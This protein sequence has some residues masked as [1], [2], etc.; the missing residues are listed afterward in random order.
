M[1]HPLTDR[2][3]HGV[4][5]TGG[6]TAWFYELRL[7]EPD[8]RK[9]RKWLMLTGVL[10]ILG[11]AAAII[12]PPLATLTM[13]VFIGWILVYAGVVMAV[14]SW[15]QRKAGRTWDRALLAL[16]AF[17]IGV[18]MVLFPDDGA[19]TLTL[20]LVIWF[21]ASG[22]VQLVAARQLWG[23]PGVGWMVFGGVLSILLAALVA[24]DLPSSAAWAIGLLV[25]VNLV[26][27]GVRALVAA[28]LLKRAFEP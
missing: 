5:P 14:H 12:V 3:F 23:L 21:I 4:A 20:L 28:S 19:L 9:A 13:T 8:L 25:G 7:S 26:F 15:T 22:V 17:I 2:F 1:A 11:G 27:W 16:L 10:A 18:Y 6:T 24:L